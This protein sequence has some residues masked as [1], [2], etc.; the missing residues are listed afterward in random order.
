MYRYLSLFNETCVEQ[1][2]SHKKYLDEDVFT[3]KRIY[4]SHKR[5]VL[6][7]RHCF[8]KLDHIAA[9]HGLQIYDLKE[10]NIIWDDTGALHIVDLTIAKNDANWCTL[11]TCM[12]QKRI[13][14][15]S[16]LFEL[17]RSASWVV[18][19]LSNLHFLMK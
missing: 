1:P 7:K 9:Q 14:P 10:E 13:Q 5:N 16:N 17:S 3:F 18:S 15:Y 2:L 11:E 4:S 8:E 19:F 12:F 6:S